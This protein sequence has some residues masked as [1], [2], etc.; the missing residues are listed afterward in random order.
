VKQRKRLLW[1][2]L[3]IPLIAVLGF[4]VWAYTPP[5]PTLEA[6]NALKGSEN[7]LVDEAAFISF[8]PAQFSAQDGENDIGI[9]FYPGGRVDAR[10]YAPLTEAI[11]AAGYPAFIV[12]MPFNLAVFSP[13]KADEVISAYPEIEHWVIGGHSL[14]GAMATRY[15]YTHPDRV[16]GLVLLA[17]Y[18]DTSNNLANTSVEVLSIAGSLD[19]L[20]TPAKIEE[21][22]NL[23]PV[24]TEFVMIE[25]GNHAQ[26]GGYGA[27]S[28]DN[29]ATISFEAQQI[30]TRDAILDLLANIEEG[31]PA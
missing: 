21:T 23:L 5:T 28:G 7:V 31:T 30:Q 22:R 15:V 3:S 24:E 13:D 6:L 4:T 8:L 10:S 18:A 14:G 1:L 20:V 19:G 11:A 16:S 27:Q 26:F 12:P 29:P 2:I 25:G 17:A 9:I